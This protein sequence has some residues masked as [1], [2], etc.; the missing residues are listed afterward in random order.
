VAIRRPRLPGSSRRPGH[1]PGP[2]APPRIPADELVL[3][4][5]EPVTVYA[6][7]PADIMTLLSVLGPYATGDVFC[8]TDPVDEPPPHSSTISDTSATF[9]IE[10]AQ[11]PQFGS[12]PPAV[13]ADWP[14]D[15]LTG[16]E[17][18]VADLGPGATRLRF[19]LARAV[20]ASTDGVLVDADGCLMDLAALAEG[21]WGSLW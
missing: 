15:E 16:Y 13:D 12:R 4:A 1:R 17:I 10:V 21:P 3:R 7:R 5:V 8:V 9:V 20:L 19:R 2:S 11:D 6:R 18:T 14:T